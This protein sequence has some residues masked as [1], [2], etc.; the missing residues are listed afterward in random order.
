MFDGLIDWV[1]TTWST[2]DNKDRI[3]AVLVI[4]IAFLI[5]AGCAPAVA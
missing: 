4:A 1:K 5:L 3:I 2:F